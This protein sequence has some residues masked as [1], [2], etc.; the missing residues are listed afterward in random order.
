MER[1]GISPIIATILLIIM[2]VGIAALMYTWMSGMFTQLTTQ[3][4]QQAGRLGGVDFTLQNI[5][6]DD[7]T[8]LFLITVVN[9][10]SVSLDFSISNFSVRVSRQHKL[11]GDA[12]YFTCTIPNHPSGS[13]RPGGRVELNVNCP[14]LVPPDTTLYLYT[15]SISYL[16]ISRSITYA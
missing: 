11:T 10:G 14:N 6:Y 4:E 2:T 9:T 3:A 16:G 13:L 15:F 1:R 5:V 7:T 12:N 8:K